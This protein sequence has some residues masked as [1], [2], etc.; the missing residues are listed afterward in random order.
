MAGAVHQSRTPDGRTMIHDEE[1]LV[2]HTWAIADVRGFIDGHG[3]FEPGEV[4]C[5]GCYTAH[6]WP[7]AKCAC[8]DPYIARRRRSPE[9]VF[10]LNA[11]QKNSA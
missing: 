1:Y 11:K 5:K 4:R 7:L 9:V 3:G 2:P 8:P 6:D 10:D